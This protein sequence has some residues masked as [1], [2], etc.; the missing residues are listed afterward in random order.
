MTFFDSSGPCCVVCVQLLG[1]GLEVRV[2]VCEAILA[3]GFLCGQTMSIS[4]AFGEFR[5]GKTRMPALWNV[6]GPLFCSSIGLVLLSCFVFRIST[7]TV[8]Y[9]TP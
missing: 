4:E 1:G 2:V 5:T 7:H 8:C 9:G 6:C 3:E